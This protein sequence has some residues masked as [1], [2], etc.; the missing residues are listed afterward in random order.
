[1]KHSTKN[2]IKKCGCRSVGECFHNIHSELDAIN[3][4]VDDFATEMK[5][6]LK[7][8]YFN[9]Y[10]GWDDEEWTPEMIRTA[11]IDHLYKPNG[12]MVDVANFA[13]FMWNRK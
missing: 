11:L 8:K 6:K 4:C 9:G 13:M 1:M 3:A 2:H 12:D 5:E 7:A 10:H